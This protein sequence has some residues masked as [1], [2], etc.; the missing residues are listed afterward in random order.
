MCY[1]PPETTIAAQPHGR[2]AHLWLQALTERLLLAT[3]QG[4][5]LI[6]GDFNAGVGS[7]PDPW[8]TDGVD[9]I[10]P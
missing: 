4:H 10:Q 3:A 8:V 7:L 6:A 5:A 1:V 2:S 9:S